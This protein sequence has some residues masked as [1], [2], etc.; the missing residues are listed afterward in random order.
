MKTAI[1]LTLS[2]IV[3]IAALTGC[4]TTNPGTTPPPAQTNTPLSRFDITN[5][6]IAIEGAVEVATLYAIQENPETRKYFVAALTALDLALDGGIV[7]PQ[8][9]REAIAQNFS[10]ESAQEAWLAV[11]AGLNIYRAYGAR[12]VSERLDQVQYLRPV[13]SALRAGILHGL[14]GPPVP[15]GGKVAGKE[16]SRDGTITVYPGKTSKAL[17]A[18]RKSTIGPVIIASVKTAIAI[19]D[20]DAV[21]YVKVLDVPEKPAGEWN[22]MASYDGGRTWGV[23]VAWDGTA[24]L[25]DASDL[26]IA[27]VNTEAD[28][29]ARYRFVQGKPSKRLTPKFNFS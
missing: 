4:T 10:E 14:N 15:G 13:L 29:P 17:T 20:G 3:A 26:V 22:L 23:F 7:D 9:V 6:A 2:A 27:T 16:C 5:T 1:T 28:P 24:Y 8:E 12:V 25:F 18:P 21:T 11:V 19:Q